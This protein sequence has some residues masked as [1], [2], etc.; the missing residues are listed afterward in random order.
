MEKHSSRYLIGHC[1]LHQ[2]SYFYTLQGDPI[3]PSQVVQRQIKEVPLRWAVSCLIASRE[4]N[5]KNKL[6]IMD[7]T[8]PREPD[9]LDEH[10]N[11]IKEGPLIPVKYTNLAPSFCQQHL[12]FIKEFQQEHLDLYMGYGWVAA[13]SGVE[14]SEDVLYKIM[15]WQGVWKEQAIWEELKNKE[16]TDGQSKT[17]K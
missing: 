10:G 15:E 2:A 7:V 17:D 3:R 9:V 13:P 5:G 1:W 16:T 6:S 14:V 11:V 4:K 8:A 12:E